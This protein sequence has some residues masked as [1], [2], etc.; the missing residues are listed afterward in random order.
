MKIRIEISEDE[1]MILNEEI[2]KEFEK[3]GEMTEA[4]QACEAG[5]VAAVRRTALAANA[6]R[7]ALREHSITPDRHLR[8][9]SDVSVQLRSISTIETA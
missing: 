9:F 3:D 1:R 2:Q 8:Y 5:F 6:E 7:H 4:G